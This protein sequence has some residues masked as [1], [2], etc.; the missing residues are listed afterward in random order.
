MLAQSLRSQMLAVG[1]AAVAGYVDA[2]AFLQLGGFFVSFMS[3]NTTRLG[4]D[5][6]E[7]HNAAF[8][9]A[10]L[11]AAFVVGAT[12]G[13]L[14][15]RQTRPGQKAIILGL[16]SILLS[17]ASPLLG[18]SVANLG[19]LLLATAMGAVNSA[20]EENGDTRFGVTYMTGALV[21]VGQRLA[22]ALNGG[23]LWDWAPYLML[24]GGLAIGASVGAAA[25]E[26]L[27]ANAIWLSAIAAACLAL[28]AAAEARRT[29]R[30]SKS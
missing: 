2:V 14:L 8:L 26:K 20:F 28:R 27:G 9:A 18:G 17:C 25:S 23:P 1:I 4:V 3:G 29:I 13:S 15:G 16:V 10:T 24:W 22:T 11:I 30:S 6:A 7:N 21:K 19:A 5:L 12:A